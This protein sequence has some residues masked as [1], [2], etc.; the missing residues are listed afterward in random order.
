[1][2]TKM[3]FILSLVAA[4]CGGTYNYETPGVTAT[5]QL[6]KTVI[7]CP[8][9]SFGPVYWDR[10]KLPLKVVPPSPE[11][12]DSL[13]LAVE[14]YAMVTG[15]HLLSM[16]QGS[17]SA[18]LI[19]VTPEQSVGGSEAVLL[20]DSCHATKTVAVLYTS[21]DPALRLRAAIHAL[22]HVLAIRGKF[23]SSVMGEGKAVKCDWS[24]C[25]LDL[26][27]MQQL[28]FYSN[29]DFNDLRDGVYKE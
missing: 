13:Q 22:G 4:G 3:M 20:H 24:T 12:H 10:A 2:K 5:P 17:E 8:D 19:E 7:N 27:T 25:T 26:E 29:A 21:T 6:Q 14:W 28:E 16:N 23:D 11:W 15:H 9:E 18:K 1:M